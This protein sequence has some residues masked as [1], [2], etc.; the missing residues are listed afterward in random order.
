MS[1]LQLKLEGV[2]ET[3]S[4]LTKASDAIKR[5][6]M[7]VAMNAGGGIIKNAV[8]PRVPQRTKLLKQAIGVK[9]TQKKNGEWFLVV[10]AKRGMKRAVKVTR[11]GNVR[12]LS[13]KA[14]SNLKFTPGGA[15]RK[16][17]DPARYLHL[18]NKGTKA[19]YVTAVNKKVLASGGVIFGR[20]VTVRAR[21]QRFMEAAA[22]IAGPNAVAKTVSKLKEQIEQ[23]K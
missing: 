17:V 10:G 13:K 22:Q 14:T 1:M 9:V 5:K 16:M 4:A 15:S 21:A 6:Y 8:L 3:L 20:R 2:K 18:A 7:R 11:S 12:A 23:H 19:H